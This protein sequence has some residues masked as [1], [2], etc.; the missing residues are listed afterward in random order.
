[1]TIA[2]LG[3]EL[4][5]T[6]N[7]VVGMDATGRVVLRHRVRRATLNALAANLPQCVERL[8]FFIR[9]RQNASAAAAFSSVM[10]SEK[11]PV[12]RV[13]VPTTMA[14][15]SRV[16]LAD[17]G[18]PSSST[19]ADAGVAAKAAGAAMQALGFSGKAPVERQAAK[20]ARQPRSRPKSEKV[21]HFL[22]DKKVRKG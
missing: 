14:I 12:A 21:A 2:T 13:N 22:I 9:Q 8:T 11:A 6:L 4:G 5:K 17:H 7:T 20:V 10:R 1:M 15:R 3:M 19:A 16:A 18:L